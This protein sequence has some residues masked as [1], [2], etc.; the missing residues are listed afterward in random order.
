M[1]NLENLFNGDA[2]TT[3]ELSLIARRTGKR[4]WIYL[5]AGGLCCKLT[6]GEVR[7]IL[8]E[9]GCGTD[10]VAMDRD[11]AAEFYELTEPAASQRAY[12]EA[13]REKRAASQRAYRQANRTGVPRIED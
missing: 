5:M 13:N 2:Y 1:I 10:F 8:A 7:V 9:M 12:C 6:A 4:L 3:G 11:A